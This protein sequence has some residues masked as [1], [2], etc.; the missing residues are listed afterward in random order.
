[1]NQAVWGLKSL[2]AVPGDSGFLSG[3]QAAKAGNTIGAA[4][5]FWQGPWKIAIPQGSKGTGRGRGGPLEVGGLGAMGRPR[6][7]CIPTRKD[8]LVAAILLTIL[9]SRVP[10]VPSPGR[11]NTKGDYSAGGYPGLL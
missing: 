4:E 1:M 8:G 2:Q 3:S 10:A 11:R 5:D 9:S 7:L 6:K